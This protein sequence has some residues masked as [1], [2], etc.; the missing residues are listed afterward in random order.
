MDSKRN[1][2][3]GTVNKREVENLRM[4]LSENGISF[5]E[6]SDDHSEDNLG[7]K[8]QHLDDI[9]DGALSDS[10]V[11]RHRRGSDADT[12]EWKWGEFPES[13]KKEEKMDS[14]RNSASDTGRW[15][16]HWRKKK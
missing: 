15:W 16:F 3:W 1:S 4:N 13:K 12:M 8:S 2:A 9:A 14:K 10:E 5:Q 7:N 11:D 6:E